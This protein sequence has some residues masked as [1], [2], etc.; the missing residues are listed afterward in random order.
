VGLRAT[1][2]AAI[3]L[4]SC[5]LAAGCGSGTSQVTLYPFNN[6]KGS[7]IAACKA[8]T[9]KER[10]LSPA[11][12]NALEANCAH[13]NPA[14]LRK[15][16]AASASKNCQAALSAGGLPATLKSQLESACAQ[17]ANATGTNPAGTQSAAS[18]ACQQIVKSTVPLPLQKQAL[19]RCP[20]S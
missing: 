1:G 9:A 5:V 4:A 3:T 8:S 17:A 15:V 13:P 10:T 2:V 20:K 11:L 16:A 14:A 7:E 19:A 18:Q 6:A 12:R